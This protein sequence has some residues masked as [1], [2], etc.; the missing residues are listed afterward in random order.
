[1]KMVSVGQLVMQVDKLF[2]VYT[3]HID[4]SLSDSLVYFDG[5]RS[6]SR[7]CLELN[8]INDSDREGNEEVVLMLEVVNTTQPFY[9]DLN[10]SFMMVEILDDD[11]K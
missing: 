5:T 2:C 6:T 9:M 11:S 3:Y 8:I 7:Q 1:M 10:P 4:L